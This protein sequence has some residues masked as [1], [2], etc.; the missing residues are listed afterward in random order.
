M[1]FPS[2]SI[3]TKEKSISLLFLANN[4]KSL[5]SITLELSIINYSVFS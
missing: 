2:L 5:E 4:L 1:F 3:L